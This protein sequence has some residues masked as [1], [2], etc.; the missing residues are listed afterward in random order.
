[1][2]VRVTL[3]SGVM[4]T[5]PETAATHRSK[6]DQIAKTPTKRSEPAAGSR[7]AQTGDVESLPDQS[8]SPG[9]KQG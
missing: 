8:K 2:A 4:V 1:M 9:R 6:Q 7:G 3:A 5:V